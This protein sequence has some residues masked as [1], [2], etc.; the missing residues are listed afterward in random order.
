MPYVRDAIDKLRV[1]VHAVTAIEGPFAIAW[2]DKSLA[3]A[4]E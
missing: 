3:D 2:T 1:R 4:S